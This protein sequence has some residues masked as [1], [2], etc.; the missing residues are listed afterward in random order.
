MMVKVFSWFYRNPWAIVL[1]ACLVAGVVFKDGI[2]KIVALH[3]PLKKTEVAK[4]ST[5]HANREFTRETTY[6]DGKKVV[7]KSVDLSVTETHAVAK[8]EQTQQE[9]RKPFGLGP[10]VG[11]DIVT[12]RGDVGVFVSAWDTLE[13]GVT[14]PVALEFHPRADV[15]W[16]A[17]RF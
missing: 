4:D 10:Q 15:R 14:N 1:L 11:Y 17:V 2:V 13:A 5:K 9:V 3:N 12:G 8:T 6:P 16:T 7:E